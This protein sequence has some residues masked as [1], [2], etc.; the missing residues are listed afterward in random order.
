M[1]GPTAT[2]YCGEPDEPCYAETGR[3]SAA[4]GPATAPAAPAD[5]SEEN[6][7]RLTFDFKALNERAIKNSQRMA[8]GSGDSDGKKSNVGGWFS[9]KGEA[10]S[11]APKPDSSGDWA[12]KIMAAEEA[13]AN[14]AEDNRDKEPK[15]NGAPPANVAP[16]EE[17]E[18]LAALKHAIKPEN[19]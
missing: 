10:K 13:A 3:G 19:I 7:G 15:L 18:M 1:S 11:G 6:R 12:E 8:P 14:A 9:K 2:H 16:S 17:D 4:P 5:D